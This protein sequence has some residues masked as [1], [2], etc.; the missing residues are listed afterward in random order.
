MKINTTG[1]N[2]SLKA[3]NQAITEMNMK[4]QDKL[5]NGTV[6]MI[7]AEK[8]FKANANVIKTQDKMLGSVID[9]FV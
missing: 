1:I 5:I 4:S 7:K 8:G 3:F 9:I 6:N 2:K